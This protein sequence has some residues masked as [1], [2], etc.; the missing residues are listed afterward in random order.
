MV[1]CGDCFWSESI[2]ASGN[3]G[4]DLRAPSFAVS[5]DFAGVADKILPWSTLTLT[6]DEGVDPADLNARVSVKDAAGPP[7]TATWLAQETP[8]GT[9]W[10]GVRRLEGHFTDL[11]SFE[12]PRQIILAID[13]GV[14]DL[15][16][17]EGSAFEQSFGVIGLGTPRESIPF[18]TT[19]LDLD[20]WGVV[21]AVPGD[22]LCEG[23]GCALVGPEHSCGT[24]SGFAARLN[25]TGKTKILVRARALVEFDGDFYGSGY[26]FTVATPGGEVS[27]APL[28]KG[29][30]PLAALEVPIAEAKFSTD[31][32]TTEIPIPAG[33]TEVGIAL[34]SHYSQCGYGMPYA[35]EGLL[36][37][38]ITLE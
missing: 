17:N 5:S 38:S 34:H 16:G 13:A 10:S 22:G 37:D 25:V 26:S 33:S 21:K 3:V 24:A 27:D 35:V 2:E 14:R 36:V 32:D 1:S 20:S 11:S 9:D 29:V 7:P 18:D 19:S 28:V 4:A 30:L 8:T 31:W 23:D 12:K 6:S 15:A